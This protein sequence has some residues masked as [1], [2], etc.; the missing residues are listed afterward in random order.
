MSQSVT[1]KWRLGVSSKGEAIWKSTRDRSLEESQTVN[2]AK[3]NRRATVDMLQGMTM[4][5]GA[6]WRKSSQ[7]AGLPGNSAPI[8]ACHNQQAN[9]CRAIGS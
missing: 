8:S 9:E 7:N 1:V 3:Q 2:H 5:G 6:H 4:R